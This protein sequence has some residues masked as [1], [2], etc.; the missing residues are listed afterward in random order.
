MK[1][2][3]PLLII[4][5][6]VA[7]HAQ[8]GK[9]TAPPG[10]AA[11]ETAPAEAPTWRMLSAK[12]LKENVQALLYKSEFKELDT[13]IA[14]IDGKG[15]R[16]LDGSWKLTTFL[17]GVSQ[18]R[19]KTEPNDWKEL[20][21]H[22][23]AWD[24]HSA[25]VFTGNAVAR[26][27]LNYAYFI[28]T[29]APT[30]DVKEEQWLIFNSGV[31][32]ALESYVELLKQPNKCVDTYAQLLRIGLAQGWE[33][34]KMQLTLQE[35]MAVAPDYY[36]CYQM[37]GYYTLENWY[38]KPGASRAFLASIPTMATGGHGFEIYTRTAIALFPYYRERFF[39]EGAAGCADWPTMKKGFEEILV[40]F[41]Q[42]R[43]HRNLFAAY[44][45][46][47]R[48][49]DTARRMLGELTEKNEIVA[50]AWSA[51]GGLEAG[52]KWIQQT[53]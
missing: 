38:G 27:K 42:S 2:Q 5:F 10:A 3:L 30:K 15:M 19:G 17:D 11:P 48:D 39:A 7:L 6:A 36:P 43:W 26:T 8:E 21:E 44:A 29:D 32:H 12:G 28:R 53:P 1:W 4:P 46:V 34:D 40:R 41:P 50:E 14:E 49:R 9:P 13:M 45:C 23:K 37:L 18:P 22:L 51:V 24:Q 33:P 47:A 25:T 31:A 16:F 20:F 52:K 35:S